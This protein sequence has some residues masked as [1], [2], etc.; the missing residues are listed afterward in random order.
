LADDRLAVTTV[1]IITG[2]RTTMVVHYTSRVAD[3]M[4]TVST[5]P[6]VPDMQTLVT[7]FLATV[8]T[9]GPCE[10]LLV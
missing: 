6:V 7:E 5:V 4:L 9:R 3:D 10:S 2:M 8:A 1:P